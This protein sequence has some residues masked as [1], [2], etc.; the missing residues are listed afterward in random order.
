MT[1]APVKVRFAPSPTG[2]LHVGAARTALL[3]W[4]FARSRGGSLLLRIDD[5]DSERG[6]EVW[7]RSIIA[8]LERLGINW[9]E[10]PVRQSDRAD[11]YGAALERLRLERRDGAY[12]F[13]G[14]VVA[15]A[16]GSAL[17]HLA[18]AV[19]DVEDRITH[20]L[21]G[22]DHLSN[23]ELQR[24]LIVA[25]GEL[26]PEYVHAPLLIGDDGAKLSKRSG[27]ATTV[28]DLVDLGFPPSAIV[29]AL[30]LSL[31]DFGADEVMLSP[32]D[33]AAA[34]SIDRLH[35]ADSRFD[36]AKLRWIS[37]RHIRAMQADRFAE[38]IDPFL[39]RLGVSAPG[40]VVLIAAQTDGTTFA[41][42]AQAAAALLAPPLPDAAAR[43]ALEAPDAEAALAL[44][45]SLADQ[46][47]Q[48]DLAR[49]D[50]LLAR[51]RGELK[52][53]GV[54]VGVGLKALRAAAT[55]RL[56][57]PELRYVLAAMPPERLRTLCGAGGPS[58]RDAGEGFG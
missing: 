42:C 36:L 11:L 24:S 19:D 13:R 6:S 50:D 12:T 4:A 58:A 53:S 48:L 18:T 54:P 5:T 57:G 51:L 52:R 2:P 9:D 44:F 39:A 10:G 15:R 22:R 21:R 33:V 55:G 35:T 31:A 3:N 8:S 7:T 46:T 29:N 43:A 45:G 20:V 47:Q 34:F 32:A 17:Y 16:D 49:S 30:A 40:E 25:L 28:D 23:T 14:R 56:D 1:A 38:A 27:S 41:E 26:P 37:G